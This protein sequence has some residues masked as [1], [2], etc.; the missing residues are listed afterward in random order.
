MQL[1]LFVLSASSVVL[2]LVPLAA[3][4]KRL[5]THKA[6]Q[7]VSLCAAI[8]C[9]VTAGN[10][11]RQ[12]ADEGEL[13]ELKL[14]AIKADVEDEI[15]TSVFISQ[16]Q[17]QQEAEL[18]LTSPGVDVEAGRQALEAIYSSDLQET[19]SASDS[20]DYPIYLE[21][22]KSMEA[23]KSVTWIVENV[24]KMGGRNFAKGKVKLESI[25]QQ[26][27]GRLNE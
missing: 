1:K 16:Q 14:R 17:R 2:W 23:G 26:F 9:A 22:C 10:I 3:L 15:S 7:G 11:A 25:L 18:I 13:E 8:A 20:P 5:D 21:V 12:L 6:V 4:D 19:T 27:E 24:L